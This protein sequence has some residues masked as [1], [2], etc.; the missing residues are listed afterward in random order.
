MA[1]VAKAPS[2]KAPAK[3]APARKVDPDQ[4]TP[5]PKKKAPP[6]PKPAPAPGAEDKLY[7]KCLAQRDA[8]HLWDLKD[9]ARLIGHDEDQTLVL[10]NILIK[11]FL[12]QPTNV[13]DVTRATN[14]AAFRLRGRSAAEK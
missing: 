14:A 12:F 2:A 4:P 8:G 10:C 5:A 11:S 7:E 13:E 9:L 6:K 1:P 3:K